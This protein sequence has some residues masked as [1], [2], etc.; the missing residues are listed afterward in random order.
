MPPGSTR[1]SSDAGSVLLRSVP[2]VS[3]HRPGPWPPPL[4]WERRGG[5]RPLSDPH[6]GLD[7]ARCCPPARPTA[8]CAPVAHAAQSPSAFGR[9][10]PVAAMSE[11]SQR[12]VG[13]GR[14]ET[15]QL[16]EAVVRTWL[17]R[18]GRGGSRPENFAF[19]EA[20]RA[21]HT[22]FAV[23]PPGARPRLSPLP[24]GAPLSAREWRQWHLPG[25]LSSARA[26]VMSL[27][28]HLGRRKRSASS[29]RKPAEKVAFE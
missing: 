9:S 12:E 24:V 7:E 26:S 11:I 17:G 15:H 1:L 16:H 22:G 3:I 27:T 13:E 2:S 20:G 4:V 21:R 5:T 6:S 18:V 10:L 28:P 25:G 14:A 29:P 19:T 8:P 23:R